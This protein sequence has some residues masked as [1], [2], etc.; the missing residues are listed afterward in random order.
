[1]YGLPLSVKV[2]KKCLMTNQKPFSVNESD[3][4]KNKKKI[5]LSFDKEGVCDAC[6]Y[7]EEK[8]KI[9][10]H[11]RE[12]LLIQMLDKYRSSNENYDCIVSGSGGKDSMFQAHILKYKY[13]MNPLT[14][15]YSPILYTDVGRRNMNSWIYKGGFD[16]YLFTPNGRVLSVLCKESFKNFLHPIQ[17]FKIGIKTFAVKMALKLNIKLVIYGEPYAE[18]GS[19]ND[20]SSSIPSYPID[21]LGSDKKFEEHY[22]SGIK[23]SELRKKYNFLSQNDLFPYVPSQLDEIK[24]SNIRVDYLG[25]YLNWDPQQIFYYAAENSGFEID[26]FRTNSTYGRYSGIDD[27]FES[28]HFYCQYI[29]FGIGR[30]RFDVSQEIRS[31]HL[32]RKEGVNLCKK[33]ENEF[34]DRYIDDCL[35]FLNIE[36][37]EAD[38]IFD[39]FRP[40]HL[41]EKKLNKWKLKQNMY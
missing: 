11:Q 13:N 19:D 22:I 12:K 18:Y 1:M 7:S 29:K 30:C 3:N 16:N 25:W 5:G 36:R 17:P 8:K 14:V 21:W 31:G 37:K 39:T 41:W 2:C 35:N 38:Q 15:T 26:D 28:L 33:Y 24:K 40:K 10:W 23:I 4:S 27:K 6:V 9:D 20:S 32:T 34:P